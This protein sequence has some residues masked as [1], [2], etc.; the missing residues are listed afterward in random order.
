MADY[1]EDEV[2]LPSYAQ[3]DTTGHSPFLGSRD[4]NFSPAQDSQGDEGGPLYKVQDNTIDT[5]EITIT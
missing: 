3:N 4:I 5:S 1:N 2:S